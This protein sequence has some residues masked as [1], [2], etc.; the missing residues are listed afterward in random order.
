MTASDLGQP[1]CRRL[2][3]KDP[4]TNLSFLIDTGADISVLPNNL[5]NCQPTTK[6]LYA[7]N[8][9]TIPT[10]GEKLL[11]LNMGLLRSFRWLFTIADVNKPIIGADFLQNYGL[12]VDLKNRKLIDSLTNLKVPGI[13]TNV[14]EAT[15]IR[16]VNIE[17]PFHDILAEFP[18]L[19]RTS[20]IREHKA[21]NFEHQI[22][23]TGHPV[24]CKVRRLDPIKLAA[25]KKEFEHLME[26][27][28]IR[29]S[30]SAWASALHMVKK[31]NGEWR[32]CGDY[33]QLNARTVPDRYPLPNIRD[34]TANLHG[35]KIFSKIDLVKAFHQI[36]MASKDIEKTALITPFG[37]FEY[38]RMP[39][40]LRNAAQSCQRFVHQVVIGLDFCFAYMDDFL[41]ASRNKEE[42]EKHLRQLFKRLDEYGVIIN[43]GKCEFGKSQIEFLGYIVSASGITPSPKK[44][45]AIRN[46]KKPETI[47]DLRRFLGMINFYRTSIQNAAQIQAPLNEFQK[48]NPKKHQELVW[49]QEQL[50]SFDKLKNSLAEAT[51]IVHPDVSATLALFVD[52]S[53]FS[54][55]A[56]VQQ[57]EKDEWKPLAYFSRNLSPPQQKYS[58]YDRE[59]LAIYEAIKYF[60]HMLEAREFIIFTDHKPITY[61]FRKK[62]DT[63]SPRQFRYLNFIGQFSTDIQHISGRDNIVADALSRITSI[64]VPTNISAKKLEEEQEKD[65][66]LKTLLTGTSS[67]NLIKMTLPGGNERIYCDNL[68]GFLRPY[69]PTNLRRIIF[70]QIH[71]LSHPGVR[72]TLKMIK[73]RYVWPNINKDVRSWVQVCIPCQKSK[74]TRHCLSGPGSYQLPERRFEH[75][76]LDIVGPLPPSDGFEYC[77]TCIDR[78]SRWPEVIFLKD[79]RAETIAK[80][81]YN[82]WICRFG[83][84]LRITSDQGRQFESALFNQ[85]SK[86]LGAQHHRTTAYHPSSN[87]MIE[88]M[89]RTL[90]AAIKCYSNVKWTDV[91]PTILMGMRSTMKEDIKTTSSEMVYGHPLRIPG[92]F[93]SESEDFKDPTEFI[94]LLRKKIADLR[95]TSGS[96]HSVNKIFI[97]KDMKNSSHVFVRLDGIKKPLTAPY[98]GPYKVI[99]RYDKFFKISMDNKEKN[100]SIDRLK[101][102]IIENFPD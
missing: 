13:L 41:I 18:H 42:H 78:F 34:F 93:L 66:E 52:A 74:V 102:A 76:N 28:I 12:L 47:N 2:F 62:V 58:A 31:P 8:G 5:P 67:L 53:N 70:N 87:G 97:F 7:A 73:D 55:G 30:K 90:K 95:P 10:Y 39:F 84:P 72:A 33:R 17:A 60:R 25:A 6:S 65:E 22:I 69:V 59:L 63:S 36:P 9:S 77:L 81:F 101:P 80:E 99:K 1:S 21:T 49:S 64:D 11:T 46:Y 20:L 45:E 100:I 37:L 48:G 38:I 57:M 83:V 4:L 71:G 16:T 32:P 91:I 23:T 61:A 29:P 51:L 14:N 56:V 26:Q 98:A 85:L 15:T 75:I 86:F 88:R 89:H 92:E 3:V 94:I 44:V 35:N 19:T 27:G 40:G 68:N 82:K 54:I 79:I 43:P 96:N 24:N 50:D